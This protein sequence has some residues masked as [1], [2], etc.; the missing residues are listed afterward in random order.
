MTIECPRCRKVGLVRLE[1]VIR[2]HD[3]ERQYQCGRC[4]YAWHERDMAVAADRRRTPPRP[5]PRERRRG[6]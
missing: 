6:D 5:V 2:G 4:G 1:T 3:S